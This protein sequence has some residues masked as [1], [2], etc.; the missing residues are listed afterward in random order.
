[1]ILF[2][3]SIL[4]NTYMPLCPS[5]GKLQCTFFIHN[6]SS[7]LGGAGRG[8]QWVTS[9]QILFHSSPLYLYQ[10]LDREAYHASPTSDPL[11]AITFCPD[12]GSRSSTLTHSF[13][14]VRVGNV[15]AHS[16]ID[17]TPFMKRGSAFFSSQ[18][19]LQ[20]L[21]GYFISWSR[22]ICLAIFLHL[23]SIPSKRP[24]FNWLWCSFP[25]PSTGWTIFARNWRVCANYS[26]H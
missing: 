26:I 16:K 4:K 17:S 24:I 21:S 9:L 2:S 7:F 18:C 22:S 5:S 14:G 20:R 23:Q 3:F 19:S 12:A 15:C 25:M 8:I 1:M 13:G 11:V 6:Y 10:L